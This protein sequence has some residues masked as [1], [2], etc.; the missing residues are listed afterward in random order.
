MEHPLG[1]FAQGVAA[2]VGQLRRQLHEKVFGAALLHIGRDRAQKDR[3]AAK[4]VDLQP[5]TFQQVDVGQQRRL[6]LGR[7]LHH[8]RF[9]QQLAGH[10]AVGRGQLFKELALV[11]RVFIND[12]HL[13]PPL[14]EDV[15]AEK[16][17]HIAERLR[18]LLKIKAHLFGRPGGGRR[19]FRFGGSGRSGFR[20][21]RFGLR[22]R[23]PC[24]HVV[25]CSGQVVCVR[26]DVE[27]GLAGCCTETRH[28]RFGMVSLLFRPLRAVQADIRIQGS[29]RCNRCP[30]VL[31]WGCRRRPRQ[32][33]RFCRCRAD[34][35]GGHSRSRDRRCSRCHGRGSFG[36]LFQCAR[37]RLPRNDGS[38]PCKVIFLYSIF[39]R[40]FVFF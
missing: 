34:G 4:V 32:D 37:L 31:A 8:H 33:V 15:G 29:R 20:L 9:Q 39:T 38:K 30:A 11:G 16:F 19:L 2:A 13:V 28:N 6:L 17:A 36:V 40:I 25:L 5:G 3:I 1:L 12:A 10:I 21:C 24:C 23:V 7:E 26:L 14:C 22:G 18:P 27:L 35:P